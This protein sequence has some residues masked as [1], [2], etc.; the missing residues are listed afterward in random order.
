MMFP[1]P[2]NEKQ[3]AAMCIAAQRAAAASDPKNVT[4]QPPP[5]T[6]PGFHAFPEPVHEHI[7]SH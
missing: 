6:L 7:P 1:D 3:W 4:N 2:S 5:A